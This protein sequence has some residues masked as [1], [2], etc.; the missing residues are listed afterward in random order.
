MEELRFSGYDPKPVMEAKLNKL[1]DIINK[2][3]IKVAKLELAAEPVKKTTAKAAK[4]EELRMNNEV[5]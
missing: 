5:R 1:I 4:T 2:L 3:E